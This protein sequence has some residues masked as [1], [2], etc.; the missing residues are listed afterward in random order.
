VE[1]VALDSAEPP[2][3]GVVVLGMHRSGT[4]LAARLLELG[5]LRM[6]PAADLVQNCW[7]NPTGHWE[8]RRLMVANDRLLAALGAAWDR[9][10]V[11]NVAGRLRGL[12]PALGES[13]RAEFHASYPMTEWI[14][15][16]PRAAITLPFWRDVLPQLAVVL[17][18]RN[19]LEVARSLEA[20]N[21]LDAKRSLEL[22]ESY[23]THAL[24]ALGGLPVVVAWYPQV[25]GAPERW[26]SGVR[27]FLAGYGLQPRP[28]NWQAIDDLARP[29]LRHYRYDDAAV[30]ANDAVTAS[31][32]RLY[33]LLLRLPE[34]VDDW[35]VKDA[36]EP[37]V[38]SRPISASPEPADSGALW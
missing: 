7:S 36:G 21:G 10:P 35:T 5:G 11:G 17:M 22:W 20:R 25:L 4:S 34:Q 8:S 19:P 23:L 28:A 1:R 13:L 6:C 18:L 30:L 3:Q 14:W 16:D 33:H 9:P 31:Q 24:E 2:A 29:T 12:V 15:K 27:E 32:A 26:V 37:Q 38:T